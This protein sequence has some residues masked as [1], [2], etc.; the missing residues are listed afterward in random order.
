MVVATPWLPQEEK[1]DPGSPRN[2]PDNGFSSAAAMHY[3]Y[4][5]FINPANTQLELHLGTAKE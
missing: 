5:R 3:P 4:V 1:I 2:D